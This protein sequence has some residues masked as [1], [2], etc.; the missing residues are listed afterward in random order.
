MI[1]PKSSEECLQV[2]QLLSSNR[3]KIQK[4]EQDLRIELQLLSSFSSLLDKLEFFLQKGWFLHILDLLEKNKSLLDKNDKIC[5]SEIL[6]FLEE[7]RAVANEKKQ[8]IKPHLFPRYLQE[9]CQEARITIDSNSSHPIYKFNQSFFEVKLDESKQR[10]RLSN[11]ESTKVIEFPAD[12]EAI[13][14]YLQQEQKRV[15]GRAFNSKTFLKKLRTEYLAIIKKNKLSDGSS[16]LI[17]SIIQN[18]KKKDKNL[19]SDEFLVD[20]SKLVKEGHNEINDKKLE[21][22]Q[23]KD[24]KEGMLLHGTLSPTYVGFILFKQV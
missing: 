7:M 9:A 22:Q 16:I 4:Q 15:F 21:L 2:L 1:T 14:Y 5:N 8:I 19:N 13:I 6:S 23:T 17:R 12:I 18:M 24:M 20:L 3:I 11:Y 10:I